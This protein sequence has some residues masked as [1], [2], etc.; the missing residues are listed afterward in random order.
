MI[1]ILPPLF[2]IL[3]FM[4]ADST[5]DVQFLLFPSVLKSA[6]IGRLEALQ[7][8]LLMNI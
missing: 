4:L 7:P 8:E 3:L 5:L 6:I 2:L 1:L